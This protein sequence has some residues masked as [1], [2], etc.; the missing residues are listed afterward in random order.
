MLL[1]GDAAMKWILPYPGDTELS[2]GLLDALFELCLVDK[3]YD[4]ETWS[5]I[6]PFFIDCKSQ[7]TDLLLPIS[8]F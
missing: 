2:I 5:I 1:Y 6:M 7:F 8:D 3:D 4:A